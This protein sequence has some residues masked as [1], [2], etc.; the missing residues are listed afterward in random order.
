VRQDGAVL[1]WS[2]LSQL[3]PWLL[4]AAVV[5]ASPVR[6]AV[7]LTSTR[8]PGSVLAACQAAEMD[9]QLR[10]LSGGHTWQVWG[11]DLDSAPPLLRPGSG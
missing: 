5:S 11:P 3:L 9:V 7:R 8:F 1:D 6:R 4:A 2:L 10:A